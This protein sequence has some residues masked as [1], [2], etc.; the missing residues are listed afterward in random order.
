MASKVTIEIDSAG[1]TVEVRRAGRIYSEKYRVDAR[2]GQVGCLCGNIQECGDLCRLAG[3]LSTT[4]RAARDLM[5][6]LEV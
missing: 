4:N 6:A 2:N 5:Q 1:Y 3:P